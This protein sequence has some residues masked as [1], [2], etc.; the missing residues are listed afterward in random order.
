MAFTTKCWWF[1]S[2]KLQGYIFKWLLGI[3]TFGVKGISGWHVQSR[4]LNLTNPSSC[5]SQKPRSRLWS[6]PSPPHPQTSREH[7]PLVLSSKC[8]SNLSTYLYLHYLHLTSS[9]HGPHAWSYST[10][11]LLLLLHCYNLF[12]LSSQTDLLKIN[13]VLSFNTL[14][15]LLTAVR[16]EI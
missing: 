10:A 3:F 11:S 12:S 14:Q 13:H 2:S 4:A 6:F 15:L 5:L 16:I 1:C 8:I 9:P 7:I